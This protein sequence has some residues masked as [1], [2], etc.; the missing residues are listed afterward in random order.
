MRNQEKIK[1]ALAVKYYYQWFGWKE[2]SDGFVKERIIKPSDSNVSYMVGVATVCLVQ[3]QKQGPPS[4]PYGWITR[5]VAFCAAGDQFVK[6]LG[7]DIALG[8]AI[9]AYERGDGD[10]ISIPTYILAS[11]NGWDWLATINPTLTDV[12]KRLLFRVIPEFKQVTRGECG[13]E[14]VFTIYRCCE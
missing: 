4:P 6:R 12:E 11:I 7:R 1:D 8:R 9:K 14:Q 13:S 2:G 10:P 3:W 5:G